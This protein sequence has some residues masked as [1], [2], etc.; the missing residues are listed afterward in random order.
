MDWWDLGLR[1]RDRL[2]TVE[3]GDILRITEEFAREEA[4][5][6]ANTLRGYRAAAE[7]VAK[8]HKEGVVDDAGKDAITRLPI[9]AVAVLQRTGRYGEVE[10]RGLLDVVLAAPG[11]PMSE[12]LVL[13]ARVRARATGAVQ[14]HQNA[15]AFRLRSRSFRAG[16]LGALAQEEGRAGNAFLAILP[17]TRFE[18]FVVDA[19]A[20]FRGGHR[21]FRLLAETAGTKVR[22]RLA[23]AFLAAVAAARAFERF[24]LV[25]EAAADA[26]DL[27]ARIDRL[28]KCGV[29]ASWYDPSAGIE[30]HRKGERSRKPDLAERYAAEFTAAFAPQPPPD[31]G[32]GR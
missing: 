28:G 7:F 27:A 15:H 29:G 6:T 22:P 26:D 4:G 31:A 12:L 11:T 13:E 32:S 21:G 18:P 10:L 14:S 20:E 19:I 1:W 9:K 8:L 30:V 16:A 3:H 24:V 25:V 2:A 17:Q 5:V 23:E